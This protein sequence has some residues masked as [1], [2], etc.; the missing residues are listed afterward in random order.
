MKTMM[1]LERVITRMND[2]TVIVPI[3]NISCCISSFVISAPISWAPCCT[4]TGCPMFFI[5]LTSTQQ[6][7]CSGGGSRHTELVVESAPVQDSV[8]CTVQWC[9]A[10]MGPRLVD[11]MFS[12]FLAYL[13][14]C[15]I[16]SSRF[17]L[18]YKNH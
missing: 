12:D 5:S 16:K 11:E 13:F 2:I 3:I 15:L 9:Q 4:Y 7:C 10:G 6:R 17:Q 14:W 18:T 8:P 1:M